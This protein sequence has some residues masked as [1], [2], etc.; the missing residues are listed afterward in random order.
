MIPKRF[1]QNLQVSRS[2]RSQMF[3]KIGVLDNFASF[4][5]K[6]L[7]WS[8]FLIKLQTFRHAT[9]LKR[10]SKIGVFLWN[11]RN[12]KSIFLTEHLRWLLL[13]VLIIL[14]HVCMRPKVLPFTWQFHYGQPWDLKS[15]SKFVPLT[16]RFY[17][18][19]FPNHGKI[20]M[21][22]R[23]WYLLFNASLINAKQMSR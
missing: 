9:L 14:G 4:T 3:S 20:L 16:W 13:A 10:D 11:L 2:N 19:N 22:M 23:K 6:Q 17:C 12:F 21:H 8:L 15:L 18:D 7:R 1:Q 5:R